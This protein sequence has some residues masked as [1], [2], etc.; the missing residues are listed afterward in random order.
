VIYK[1]FVSYSH[2]ADGKLA[3][4]LQYSLQQ[5]AKPWNRLRAMRVFVDTA[6][7]SANPA[8]WP[9]IEQALRESE[10]FILLASPSSAQSFWVQKEVE[11]WLA[12]GRREQLLIVLTEGEIAWSPTAQT[13]DRAS[14]TA[15]PSVV[16]GAIREEP[17]YTD[18][19]WARHEVQLS[20]QNPRFADAVAGLASAIRGISKD[21][22]HGEH[23]SQHRKLVRL[24][25][26]AIGSLVV[27]TLTALGAALIAIRQ[28]DE[29]RRQAQIALGR[30]LA[31]QA[32]VTRT[33]RAQLLPL[34]LLQGIESMRTFPSIEADQAI[35]TTLARV[36]SAVAVMPHSGAVD[37]VVV[38]PTTGL[39][40]TATS[41]GVVALWDRTGRGERRLTTTRQRASPILFSP[42]GTL[43]ATIDRRQ[44]VRVWDVSTARE[45]FP[46]L[47]LEGRTMRLAFSPNSRMLGA[48]SLLGPRSTV[49]VWEATTGTMMQRIPLERGAEVSQGLAFSLDGR[50][51]AVDYARVRVWYHRGTWQEMVAPAM[52]PSAIADLQYSP[53]G[54]YLVGA[55][56][57][58]LLVLAGGVTRSESTFNV[59]G[60]RHIVFA[61]DGTRLAGVAGNQAIVW[62]T[63]SWTQ[64][65]VMTHEEEIAAVAFSPS[66]SHLVTGSADG[67]AALW[68]IPRGE[69]LI[70]MDHGDR[71][72]S[73]AFA[74][75][76]GRIVTASADG[77][78]RIWEAHAQV[79]E[80][81]LEGSANRSDGA[82]AS[83]AARFLKIGDASLSIWRGAE[84]RVDR[85][86]LPEARRAAAL[87]AN[88]E[89][90]AI[91][92]VGDIVR[93]WDTSAEREIASLPHPGTVDWMEYT[94]RVGVRRD[95]TNAAIQRQI[96]ETGG[97]VDIGGFSADG[98]YLLTTRHDFVA[99]L[100][101]VGSS[102]LIASEP[103]ES[104]LTSA[105]FSPDGRLATL[106]LD[107]KELRVFGLPDGRRL[108]SARGTKFVSVAIG[109]PSDVVAVVEEVAFADLRIRL[110]RSSDW[111][112]L[113]GIG[114]KSRD[115][116][117]V[118][119]SDGGLVSFIDE[120][121][122]ARIV[123]TRSGA[124]V[125]RFTVG[126]SVVPVFSPDS[127]LVAVA[128]VGR[129]VR[130][131]DLHRNRERT[132][133]GHN[134]ET[135]LLA[136]TPDSQYLATVGRTYTRI[137]SAETG[138]EVARLRNSR[139]VELIQ[140]SGDGRY[141]A[142][143][144]DET[145]RI[146][147]WRPH[148]MAEAGCARLRRH[149]QPSQWPPIAGE[150]F[151][152]RIVRACPGL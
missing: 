142:T 6:S 113:S 35:R 2:S 150:P 29:A 25:R 54:R 147:M 12:L 41:E 37:A 85:M 121:N 76:A 128:G 135:L 145:T 27:L 132:S 94:R 92:G 65:T 148:D 26:L 86:P 71:V 16:H 11:C 141:L 117:V 72:V 129:T 22:L 79:E 63:E 116:R 108:F 118:L 15:L 146:W 99:R 144:D 74:A 66:G 17:L 91:A 122:V 49:T 59:R 3:P 115:Y 137:F 84:S 50:L 83:R 44:D 111:T 57:G 43:L 24:R 38:D 123:R 134:E 88:G 120:D 14:T 126:G 28:R 23:V 13:L 107:D 151:A 90:A 48:T 136:F 9:T 77:T 104:R 127:A 100:W 19:R 110:W 62:D 33:E 96:S 45:R 105:A 103:Y 102:R 80:V 89:R 106:I 10:Y 4:T 34:S 42:D 7:L 98:R 64:T 52:S 81:A 51:A 21:D 133:L 138:D 119:S 143:S 53:D 69:K 68:S 56:T 101:D 5:F 46:P 60:L 31:A 140:F 1:A 40:A 78:A 131:L 30:Q 139:Q 95:A 82:F 114:F 73:V 47:K 125:A 152:N 75:D 70:S 32:E 109:S 130:I 8:L 93:L 20:L 36:P 61:A 97:A 112:P 39:I 67:T 149:L 18:L 87:S 124:E 55:A 58:R